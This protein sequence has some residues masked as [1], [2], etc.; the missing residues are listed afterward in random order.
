MLY[1]F[2]RQNHD[3]LT[4]GASIYPQFDYIKRKTQHELRKVQAYYHGRDRAVNNANIFSR[5]ISICV[6]RLNLSPIDIL[7]RVEYE[8]P[9]YCKQFFFVNNTSPG[10]V[11]NNIFYSTSREVICSVTSNIN[12][13]TLP[14][15]WKNEQPLR[16]VYSNNTDLDYYLLDKRKDTDQLSQIPITV[17]E[18]DIPLMCMMYYYWSLERLQ[19]GF[20]TNPNVFVYRY[21]LPNTLKSNMDITIFNRFIKHFYNTTIIDKPWRLPISVYDTTR[22][23]DTYLIWLKNMMDKKVLRVDEALFNF[24]AINSENMLDVL[25]INRPVFTRQSLWS[26]WF[27]RIKYII[28]LIDLVGKRGAMKNQVLFKRLP[29]YIKQ[30]ESRNTRL[31]DIL[32]MELAEDFTHDLDELKLRVGKR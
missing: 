30:L 31:Y 8:A 6:P 21:L 29:I 26:L 7:K 18:V 25:Y 3:F 17:V 27:S 14:K 13:F 9:H 22:L 23:I 10:T 20:S 28:F 4:Y 15:T 19:V 1:F 24:K 12:L 5:M 11:F 16:I 2:T 32:P